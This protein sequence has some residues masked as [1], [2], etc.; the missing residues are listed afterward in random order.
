V[1]FELVGEPIH[2]IAVDS[3]KEAAG[4][5]LYTKSG[6]AKS[7]LRFRK[8]RAQAGVNRSF[9]GQSRACHTALEH[10]RDIWIDGQGSAHKLIIS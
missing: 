8:G 3:R 1:R 6:A 4:V 7:G 5:R 10:L 9:E 2:P